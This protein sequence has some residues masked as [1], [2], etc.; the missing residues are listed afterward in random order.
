MAVTSNADPTSSEI[1]LSLDSQSGVTINTSGYVANNLSVGGGLVVGTTNILN[2]ITNLQNT[3][4][5]A[6]NMSSTILMG[7]LKT[8]G[9]VISAELE[10]SSSSQDTD[11][12]LYVGTPFENSNYAK[13]VH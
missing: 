12:I 2:A 5:N 3:K 8:I 6:I 9:P 11:A 10:V 13:N 4:Q 1:L 7:S